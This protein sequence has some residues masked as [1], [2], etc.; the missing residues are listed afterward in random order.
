MFK[1]TNQFKSTLLLLA[2][3]IIGIFGNLINLIVFSNRKLKKK[4]TFKL[5]FY[6]AIIDTLVL[7][8]GAT[9]A[10]MT[11]GNLKMIR[12][13]SEYSCKVH[14]FLTYTLTHSSSMIL[15]IVSINRVLTVCNKSL[16]RSVNNFSPSSSILKN[17]I[18]YLCKLL[19]R[20]YHK[21]VNSL[22]FSTIVFISSINF[23]YL[24]FMRK[25]FENHDLSN[26]QSNLT[27]RV[28]VNFTYSWK[29]NKSIQQ[30]YFYNNYND[31]SN[32]GSS[33]LR[34]FNIDIK[35]HQF[36]VNISLSDDLVI[37]YP[38]ENERYNYF[39]FN[40]WI[41]I[42]MLV[43]S[44]VPFVVMLSCSIII[45]VEIKSKGFKSSKNTTI[46]KIRARSKRRN[47]KLLV[48]LTA[49]NFYFI[50]STLPLCL[51]FIYYRYYGE[52]NE[53]NSYQCFYHTLAYSNNSFSFLFN[54][55]FCQEYRKILFGFIFFRSK[56]DINNRKR[57]NLTD[58]KLGKSYNKKDSFVLSKV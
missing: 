7:L 39:L 23:H 14:T 10:L 6:L 41:W 3:I 1:E 51:S 58:V 17:R 47:I 54:L 34:K 43:Y 49:T 42:D 40:I 5:L 37:C 16:T 26:N 52:Y 48:M 46:R 11:Y 25:N 15:T 29:K 19:L 24:L 33:I 4:S 13:Y 30:E 50:L 38:R 21:N 32:D 27:K 20:F 35:R 18:I 56:N 57:L 31:S 2:V 22:I 55:T 9:D 44:I 12:L 36:Y 53:N 45:L 28:F 8:V